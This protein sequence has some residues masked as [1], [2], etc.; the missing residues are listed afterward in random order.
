MRAAD[1]FFPST[2]TPPLVSLLVIAIW[3]PAVR[4]W[5]RN[6]R[7][8]AVD[9][10]R[11]L[12]LVLASVAL[13]LAIGAAGAGAAALMLPRSAEQLWSYCDPRPHGGPGRDVNE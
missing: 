5:Y 6:E 11:Q 1:H 3:I 7:Q 12:R 8:Q 13:C 9:P 10:R 4:W 2:W